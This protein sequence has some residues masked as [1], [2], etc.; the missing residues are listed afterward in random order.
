MTGQSRIEG[1]QMGVRVDEVAS[2]IYQEL[3]LGPSKGWYRDPG[4][5]QLRGVYFEIR[6][7]SGAPHRALRSKPSTLK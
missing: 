3:P 5:Y 2:N 1:R 4:I 7:V 6:G